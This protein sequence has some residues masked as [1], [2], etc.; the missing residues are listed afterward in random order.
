MYLKRLMD[1]ISTE[2]R[3]QSHTQY[4]T[5]PVYT[6]KTGTFSDIHIWGVNFQSRWSALF[7]LRTLQEYGIP[8]TPKDFSVVF[9]AIPTGVIPLF[10][11][12]WPNS[13]FPV[14]G[15]VSK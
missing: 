3:E 4:H 12:L 5:T 2:R 15:N 1:H 7:L 14:L 6:Y 10:R 9:D 13:T 11:S 8:V